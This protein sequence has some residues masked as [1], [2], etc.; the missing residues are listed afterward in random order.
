M[1]NKKFPP[2]KKKGSKGPNNQDNNNKK[3]DNTK[4][5]DDWD[6]IP[7]P[8]PPQLTKDEK[9]LQETSAENRRLWELLNMIDGYPLTLEPFIPPILKH[10]DSYKV[11]KTTDNKRVLGFHTARKGCPV[12]A[13]P[14]CIKVLQ[15]VLWDWF[16]SAPEIQK[17]VLNL[18]NRNILSLTYV[19]DT[20]QLGNKP[21]TFYQEKTTEASFLSYQKLSERVEVCYYNN[22]TGT[23][24][25]AGITYYFETTPQPIFICND[26]ALMYH[27]TVSSI[28]YNQKRDKD[29][30]TVATLGKY[31][32]YCERVKKRVVVQCGGL[33]F[34]YNHLSN[35][36]EKIKCGMCFKDWLVRFAKFQDAPPVTRTFSELKLTRM[37]E[38]DPRNA[39]RRSMSAPPMDPGTESKASGLQQYKVS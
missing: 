4:K 1:G 26:N 31:G 29:K 33:H 21:H 23:P 7:D 18:P 30:F 32:R 11:M 8:T 24:F 10:A 36:Y 6:D 15:G 28:A 9:Y 12:Q 2:A 20:F 39:R 22:K 25:L 27:A 19:A 16:Q 37:V 5:D 34:Q 14:E 38:G 3:K 17:I 35:E 13:T